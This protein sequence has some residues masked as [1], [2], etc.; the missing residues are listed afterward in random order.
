MFKFSGK[1]SKYCRIQNKNKNKTDFVDWS[2]ILC[3]VGKTWLRDCS[4]RSIKRVS[5]FIGIRLYGQHI[6]TFNRLF[7]LL[8]AKTLKFLSFGKS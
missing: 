2:K 7:L 4:V 8:E 1:C 6:Q 5:L 3:G